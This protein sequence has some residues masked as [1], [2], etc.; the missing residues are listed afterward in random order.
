MSDKSEYE[1][2][3]QERVQDYIFRIGVLKGNITFREM[4]FLCDVL[5]LEVEELLAKKDAAIDGTAYRD[6]MRAL[7]HT[8][9]RLAYYKE[10]LTK[11][12]DFT[13]DPLYYEAMVDVENNSKLPEIELPPTEN[14][15]T[16]TT[17][18]KI[19]KAPQLIKKVTRNPRAPRPTRKKRKARH[20]S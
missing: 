10:Q 17:P 8:Q 15:D 3:S 13:A 4:S 20:L 6:I 2:T 16:C 11:W 1:R 18:K 19:K 9:R 12:M 7:G 5:A 14:K